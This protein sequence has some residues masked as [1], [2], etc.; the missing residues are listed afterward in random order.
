VRFTDGCRKG[1]GDEMANTRFFVV[2]RITTFLAL[3]LIASPSRAQP[4]EPSPAKVFKQTIYN[5]ASR[6]V[7]YHVPSDAPP[8]IQALYRALEQAE[9][10]QYLSEQ[11]QQLLLEYTE[12]ERLLGSVRTSRE[13]LYGL[14]P[15]RCG[16][17]GY[18]SPDGVTKAATVQ[19]LVA[20][21]EARSQ[22]AKQVNRELELLQKEASGKGKAGGMSAR[23]AVGKESAAL[24]KQRETWQKDQVASPVAAPAPKPWPAPPKWVGPG[25]AAAQEIVQA[26]HAREVQWNLNSTKVNS[27]RA[28]RRAALADKKGS[29]KER[30][31]WLKERDAFLKEQGAWQKEAIASPAERSAALAARREAQQER[32]A[33]Q[34]ERT[35]LLLAEAAAQRAHGNSAVLS[36]ILVRPLSVVSSP[37]GV[38]PHQPAEQGVSSGSWI[39]AGLCALGTLLL[40][41]FGL[42]LLLHYRRRA[43]SQGTVT[44][45]SPGVLSTPQV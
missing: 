13:L 42:P 27:A 3:L 28:E 12:Q 34:K 16:P 36:P 45:V 25:Q 23:D 6:Y 32:L 31:A 15:R 10:D 40:I 41:G 30:D 9:N 1:I 7:H 14:A 5:G 17:Y 19:G 2:V 4:A 18:T 35:A 26:A 44:P 38:P 29:K 11:L 24:G 39:G 8:R 37:A 20:A 21:A 43:F 33:A 22:F